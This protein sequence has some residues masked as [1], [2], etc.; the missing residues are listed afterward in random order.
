MSFWGLSSKLWTNFTPYSVSTIE[1]QQINAFWD[2]V[3]L[4][5]IHKKQN[6]IT[7]PSSRAASPGAIVMKQQTAIFKSVFG[8]MDLIYIRNIFPGA[9]P[10]KILSILYSELFNNPMELSVFFSSLKYWPD[11][12][13]SFAFSLSW[14]LSSSFNSKSRTNLSSIF[15]SFKFIC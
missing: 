3:K 4:D 1:F 8:K 9:L 5:H 12:V 13:F 6:S 2:W 11:P 14:P 15:S 7:L 10:E